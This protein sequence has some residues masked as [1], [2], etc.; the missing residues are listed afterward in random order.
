[1]RNDRRA[2]RLTTLAGAL[3]LAAPVGAQIPDPP[4]KNLQVLPKDISKRDIVRT[5]RQYATELGVRC[6]HCHVGPD[7]LEGMDFASDEK[8]AK[9]AAREMLRMV[10]TINATTIKALPARA[11]PRQTLTCITCHR[12][13]AIPPMPLHVDLAQTAVAKGGPAAVERYRELRKLHYGDGRYDFRPQ[14]LIMAAV[15]LMESSKPEEA[16]ALARLNLE[17]NPEL[18]QS[19]VVIGEVLLRKGEKD[20]ASAS[21]RKALEID[22][23]N[24]D[25]QRALKQLEAQPPR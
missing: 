12:A 22:P 11:E 13:T 3:S 25:A 24:F 20:K 15:R 19:H 4:Y 18:A 8:D 6:H 16:L 1:M 5:M 9:R 21:F 2:A 7:N 10:E 23:K 17:F 14:S